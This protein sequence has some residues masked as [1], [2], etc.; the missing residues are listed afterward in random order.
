MFKRFTADELQTT[1]AIVA[2]VITAVVFAVGIWRAFRIRP[3]EKDHLASLPL[4]DGAPNPKRNSQ[5]HG[6]TNETF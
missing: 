6:R 4:E 3:E 2:F 1:L 5:N